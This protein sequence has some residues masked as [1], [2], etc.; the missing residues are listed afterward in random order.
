MYTHFFPSSPSFNNDASVLGLGLGRSS[1][2]GASGKLGQAG[3]VDLI[4]ASV[5]NSAEVSY[6]GHSPDLYFVH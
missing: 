1:P 2:S 4:L 3:D 6:S 5:G